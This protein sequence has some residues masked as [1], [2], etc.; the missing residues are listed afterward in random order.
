MG[1]HGIILWARLD[2]IVLKFEKLP[3][4]VGDTKSHSFLKGGRAPKAPQTQ[5]AL[6]LQ[7]C[8]TF[9]GE[10]PENFLVV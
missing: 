4:S 2:I 8:V 1:Y 9:L 10:G 5:R 3:L 6:S 7:R